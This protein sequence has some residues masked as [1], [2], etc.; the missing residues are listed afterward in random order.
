MP[1]LLI[2]SDESLLDDEIIN[3][4]RLIFIND[5][6]YAGFNEEGISE[7]ESMKSI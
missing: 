4:L 6:H 2:N 5:A 1:A 3:L 7:R